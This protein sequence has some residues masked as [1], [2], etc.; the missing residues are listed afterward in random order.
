[1]TVTRLSLIAGDL[2]STVGDG[3]G[4]LGE[5]VRDTVFNDSS[6]VYLPA[7][8]RCRTLDGRSQRN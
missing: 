5:G 7:Y 2:P 1:M 4:A 6:R 8:Y 3:V